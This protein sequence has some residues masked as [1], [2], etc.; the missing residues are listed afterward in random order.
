MSN[1]ID[2]EVEYIH[3]ETGI[4]VE[5]FERVSGVACLPD[6]ARSDSGKTLVVRHSENIPNSSRENVEAIVDVRINP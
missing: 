1:A 4:E 3:A 6:P 5:T 2:A